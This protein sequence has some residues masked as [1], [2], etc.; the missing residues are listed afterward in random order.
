MNIISPRYVDAVF[1]AKRYASAVYVVVV[2][3]CPSVRPS[4]TSWILPK[5][6]HHHYLFQAAIGS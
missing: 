2:A 4:V 1:T 6:R 3:M 5:R